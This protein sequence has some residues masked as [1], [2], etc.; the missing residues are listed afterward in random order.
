LRLGERGEFRNKSTI[1]SRGAKRDFIDVYWALKHEGFQLSEV[2]N[3]FQKKY[4]ALQ[5][6]LLHIYKSLVYFTD[7]E[8]EP[9]PKMLKATDWEEVKRFFLQEVRKA[10]K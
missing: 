6:N 1:S 7:A 4:A 10:S 9:M 8:N 5:Y 3:Y 2:L